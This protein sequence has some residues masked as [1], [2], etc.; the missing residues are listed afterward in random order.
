MTGTQGL[1]HVLLLIPDI[2]EGHAFFSGVLGFELSD[3][4][5]VPGQ[6][7]ARFYH[8]NARHHT[9]ALGERPRAWPGSTT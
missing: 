4:I 1:G 2:E 6:L 9:L 7:N 8:V 5:I 3:K